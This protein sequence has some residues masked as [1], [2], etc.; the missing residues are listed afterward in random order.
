MA[1]K[2]NRT[3]T[4]YRTSLGFDPAKYI[5]KKYNV[6]LT[7]HSIER[8]K[9]RLG[10][11]NE[12]KLLRQA[13][14][15]WTR[16][17]STDNA[18]MIWQKNYMKSHESE[19][20]EFRLYNDTFFIFSTESKNPKLITVYRMTNSKI[21]RLRSACTTKDNTKKYMKYHPELMS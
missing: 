17:R 14:N 4:A 9:E 21:N 8:A 3:S 1:R 19:N 7:A 6:Y 18:D 12:E 20:I 10:I 11:R 5:T 2:N 13:F 15:A 16:G